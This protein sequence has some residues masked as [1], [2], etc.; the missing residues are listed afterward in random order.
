M[1]TIYLDHGATTRPIRAALDAFGAAPWGNPSALHRSG[2]D[3][4]AALQAARE[5][6]AA[7]VGAD[8][9][10]VYF[11]S[12]ATEGAA[13]ALRVLDFAG[14]PQNGTICISAGEHHA[15]TEQVTRC[16]RV[17]LPLNSAGAIIPGDH[18]QRGS[19]L[20]VA[21]MLA[22]NETG[23]INKLPVLRRQLAKN[24]PVPLMY[25]DAT[26]AVGHIPVSFRKLGVEYMSF[27][28]HKFGGLKG[29]GVLVIKSG[30]PGTPL[31]RG[32]GQEYGRRGGTES[33]QL[34]C[35]MAAA[36]EWNCE[37]MKENRKKVTAL[38]DLAITEIL[39][40]IPG[41]L[42]NGSL[43]DRLPGNVNI[44]VDGVSGAALVEALSQEGIYIS[45]GSACTSGDMKPSATLT[46]MGISPSRAFS[47]IR[48]TIDYENT[49]GEIK[50]FVAALEAAV[51][52][53]R[54][55]E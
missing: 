12:G 8:P 51:K 19:P 14:F 37:H 29:A 52:H 38:R 18:M 40:R 2:R 43:T 7:C 10:E 20:F 17:F 1:K 6:I 30:A 23:V 16:K 50:S 9:S 22:N 25:T 54:A 21:A 44:S 13:W 48:V 28:A 24:N 27:T 5:T 45:A 42:L 15:V 32:G 11:T 55:L 4:A 33:V 36:L 34:V 41:T 47:S 26:A 39:N 3:A 46:A 49:E 35:A 53:F 31:I